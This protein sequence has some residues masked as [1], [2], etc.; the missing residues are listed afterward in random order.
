MAEKYLA[1]NLTDNVKMD[2]SSYVQLDI[3]PFRLQ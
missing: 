2:V 3:K 1:Y